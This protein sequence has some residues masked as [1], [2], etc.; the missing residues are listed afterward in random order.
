MES[1]NANA[2]IATCSDQ[3]GIQRAV[4]YFFTKLDNSS[5]MKLRNDSKYTLIYIYS[6]I[7]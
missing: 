6:I 4:E 2:G 3:N 7:S 1:K 5:E